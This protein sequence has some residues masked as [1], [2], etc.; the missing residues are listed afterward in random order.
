MCQ[1]IWCHDKAPFTIGV[2][3]A[4]SKSRVQS[5]NAIEETNLDPPFQCDASFSTRPITRVL[6]SR[7]PTP[8]P[9]P[10][11][12]ASRKCHMPPR[13][14]PWPARA[15]LST[16]L[17]HIRHMPG[18][19]AMERRYPRIQVAA[20][21]SPQRVWHHLLKLPLALLLVLKATGHSAS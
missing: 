5:P 11:Q 13:Q 14:V 7:T 21:T 16:A 2:T 18:T 1:F 12:A 19:K 15:E 4:G 20:C 17:S 10:E 6:R 3:G 9:S 8:T